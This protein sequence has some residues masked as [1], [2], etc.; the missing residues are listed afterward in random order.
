MKKTNFGTEE[1]FIQKYKELKSSRKMA[2]FY[3]CSKTAVLNYARKIGYNSSENKEK[4]VSNYSPEEVYEKYLELKSCKKTGEYY[5]CSDTAVRNFLTQ[6]GYKL[7]NANHKLDDITDE[8]FIKKYDE[9]KSAKKVGDFFGCSDTSILQRAR[10]IG[11]DPLSNK[12]YKLTEQDK[13]D[14][15]EAYSSSTSN[16][17]AKKYKVSRGM[18]TKL[19]Y[20]AGLKGK[21]IVFENNFI[22]L[23]GKTFGKWNVLQK[24]ENRGS[25]GDIKWL[26][27]CECG[28]QKEVSSSSLRNGTSLSCGN[29]SNI[30]KGNEKIKQLLLEAKIPFEIE[31]RFKE[32]K[33]I[34]SLPFDFYVKDSYLIE[35]DGIQ[36]FEDSIFD[37]E[38]THKH[39]LIKSKW[40]KDNKIPLIRIPYTHLNNLELKDLILETSN[41]VEK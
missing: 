37:Y 32:C 15:I 16:T 19:W 3:G 20:D 25:N 28:V 23:T 18:I 33:D 10:K 1:E 24:T 31:K 41:F 26:C 22:D 34:V 40:C 14:I 4:K 13:K 29:H 35:Y 36:H 6:A 7:K 8:D 21:E 38:Y 11:Y 17:L 12:E 2:E 5:G 9:L 30:S 39:D 27:Q